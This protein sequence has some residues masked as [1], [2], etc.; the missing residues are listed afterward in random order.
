MIRISLS[1]PLRRAAA[2]A[3]AGAVTTVVALTTAHSEPPGAHAAEAAAS[4]GAPTYGAPLLQQAAADGADLLPLLARGKDGHLWDYEA[5][6]TGGWKARAD[7]GTGYSVATALVQADISDN[8]RG[9]DLYFRIGGT[10]YYTAER[11]NDTKVLGTG[12][13]QYNLIVSVGNMAGSAQPDL[14]ARGTDGQ[15]WLYQGKA[16][17]TL[18]ARVRMKDST[19]WNGMSVI[20]GR[21]DYTGDG[22]AD[23]V[24]RNSAGSLLIYPGT[25]KATADA[26]LGTSVTAATSGWKDYTAVVSTGD[27]TGDGKADLM[28]VDA[29][30]ALWLYKGTGTA[31]APFGARTQIGTSGWTQYNLLF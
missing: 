8:G 23:L 4:D 18:S 7:L 6:G 14:V 19:G 9:N 27:N 21:G 28:A 12:W 31:S 13:D 16:D 22:I 1:R 24:T 15:L 25:G 29:A 17:G 11:G 26:V 10:L 5:K 2:L 20:A 3:L 30:G